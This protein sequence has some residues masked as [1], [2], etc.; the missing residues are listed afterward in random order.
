MTHVGKVNTFLQ[1]SSR[2]SCGAP[3]KVH[4]KLTLRLLPDIQNWAWFSNCQHADTV[5]NIAIQQYFSNLLVVL[6]VSL[7]NVVVSVSSNNC[8]A[9]SRKNYTEHRSM[10]SQGV[11]FRWEN[12]A[13]ILCLTLEIPVLP[14]TRMKCVGWKGTW[15]S[16]VLSSTNN[17]FLSSL[18]RL[19]SFCC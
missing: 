3:W 1:E 16:T 10:K 17:A 6:G 2:L 19:V 14:Y 9:A 12:H 7:P 13:P 15:V 5:K 4:I 11:P 8:R 18:L